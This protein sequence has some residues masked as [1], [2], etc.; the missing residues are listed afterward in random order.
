[1]RCKPE[2]VTEHSRARLFSQCLHYT[3]YNGRGLNGDT[4]SVVHGVCR[5]RESTDKKGK[6]TWYKMGTLSSSSSMSPPLVR[7]RC[8]APEL[9]L[10]LK[11]SW[12]GQVKWQQACNS[13]I[14]PIVT[15]SLASEITLPIMYFGRVA[16]LIMSCTAA[17]TNV[18][19]FQVRR[20]WK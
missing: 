6:R 9:F 17:Q 10:W 12:L 20:S 15:K 7:N 2:T 18:M 13:P 4:S 19:Y 5:L 16:A 3:G 1:M 8:F 11:I 14:G